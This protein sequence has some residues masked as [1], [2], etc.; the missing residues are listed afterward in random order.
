MVGF[1]LVAVAMVVGSVALSLLASIGAAV[2]GETVTVRIEGDL[3]PFVV[4]TISGIRAGSRGVRFP[5]KTRDQMLRNNSFW[6][7]SKC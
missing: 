5:R 6:D 1:L 2:T 3:P 4:V 7:Q